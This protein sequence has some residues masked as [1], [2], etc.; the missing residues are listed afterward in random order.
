M[1]AAP[2]AVLLDAVRGVH[3]PARHAVRGNS[4][5]TH[6]SHR[7]GVSPEFSEYRIYRQGDDPRRIDWRLLGRS[8]RAYIRLANERAVLSTMLVVD[9]SASMAFPSATAG[10]WRM[11]KQV[12]VALSAIVHADG[13]PVGVMIAAAGD[14][15]GLSP[16]TR[17][18]VTGEIARL[19]DATEPAGEIDLGRAAAAART[20]GRMVIL[21]DLL[22][23]GDG[24]L[25]VA[26]E[27]IAAGGEAHAVHIVAQH[28]LE[29]PARAILAIDPENDSVRRPLVDATRDAYQ[30]AFAQ[31]RA[32]LA[33]DWRGAGASYTM[34]RDEE[35]A[36]RAV[37]R[38][39]T[40]DDR[41]TRPA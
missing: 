22:G 3:W 9:G 28:E 10:K 24:L 32:A 8:D 15:H 26:R 7:R 39:V 19:L 12:A 1:P 35:P 6:H 2:Y 20:A 11:A 25:R 40:P 4:S 41:M 36:D 33:T 31:W 13:D 27:H 37:R 29:P 5:G 14:P 16:R 23:N 17:R 34:V 21:S 38:I 18:G 30:E